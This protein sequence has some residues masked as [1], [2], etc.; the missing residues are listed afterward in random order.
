MHDIHG[1]VLG[2]VHLALGVIELLWVKVPSS[3]MKLL[4]A[5]RSSEAFCEKELISH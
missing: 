4:E 3:N 5:A 1:L 2:I